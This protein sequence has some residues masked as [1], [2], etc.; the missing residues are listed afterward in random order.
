MQ[1]LTSSLLEDLFAALKGKRDDK[2][3]RG[4]ARELMDDKDLPISYLVQKTRQAA[5][6]AEAER[7]DLLIRGRHA[8]EKSKKEQ[9]RPEKGL[10]ALVRKFLR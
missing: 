7:L 1:F 4:F 2:T 3:V 9:V 8:V 6:T 5:G 10:R